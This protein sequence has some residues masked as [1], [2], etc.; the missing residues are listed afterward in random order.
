MQVIGNI[1]AA[2]PSVYL[3]PL[4]IKYLEI[5]KNEALA[6]N[7][8]NFNKELQLDAKG[9][10][11]VKWWIHNIHAQ[12]KDIVVEP[13]QVF[14]YTD[15]SLTGWGAKLG[16][17]TTGGHWAKEEISHINTLELKAMIMGL[18]SLCNDLCKTHIKIF[19]DNTT[20]KACIEKC[21]STHKHL[22]EI[23]QEIYDWA[24]ERKIHLSAGYIKGEENIEA[25]RESRIKNIDT[26][27]MI[28]PH[29]FA[30]ICEIFGSPN[31]DLFATRINAQSH[32]YVSWKP[33]PYAL[34]TDAFSIAWTRDT[35]YAFPPFSLI[36]P[37]LKRLREEKTELLMVAPL[38]PTASWFPALLRQICQD[39]VILPPNSL[40]LPQDPQ[41]HHPLGNR[42]VLAGMKISGDPLRIKHYQMKLPPL[43]WAPGDMTLANNI[44]HVSIDGCSFATNERLIHFNPL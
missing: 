33:D 29:I 19:T 14:L 21:G 40:T 28:K 15:A 3:A 22:L 34:C 8:G 18:Q 32:K 39:P 38:W 6:K 23:T 36:G 24:M 12:Y 1:V 25:D 16:N 26:E 7:S 35:Y 31:I 4:R 30:K 2:E 42:L 43:C 13:P 5:L 27:W 41:R 37:V 17:V 20:A 11:I 10:K 44:G 9:R